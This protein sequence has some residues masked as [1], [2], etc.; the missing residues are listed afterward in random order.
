MFVQLTFSTVVLFVHPLERCSVAE[1]RTL[2]DLSHASGDRLRNQMMEQVNFNLRQTKQ[3]KKQ[4]EEM[5]EQQQQIRQTKEVKH[6]MGAMVIA[7]RAPCDDALSDSSIAVS[8][9]FSP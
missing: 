1:L 4:Q 7:S 3:I 5:K 8:S 6:M 2:H 9:L